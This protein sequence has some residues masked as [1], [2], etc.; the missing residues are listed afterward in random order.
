MTGANC[1]IVSIDDDVVRLPSLYLPA[2][3]V[4]LF[5]P[6]ESCRNRDRDSCSTS[7]SPLTPVLPVGSFSCSVK[8]LRNHPRDLLS[9][10][11]LPLLTS[12]S[13]FSSILPESE[14]EGG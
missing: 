14:E 9:L 1:S 5:I 11:L 3:V 8:S 10:S 4:V 7:S 12:F 2:E 13:S 6:D